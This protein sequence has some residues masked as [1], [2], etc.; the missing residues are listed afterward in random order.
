MRFCSIAS[1][2]SGNCTYVGSDTTHFLVDAGISAKRIEEGLKKMLENRKISGVYTFKDGEKKKYCGSYE[3]KALEFM[4]KVLAHHIR[5][6]LDSTQINH[7]LS[8]Q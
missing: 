2:S 1:G 4:D 8:F 6:A 7:N 3:L 5:K